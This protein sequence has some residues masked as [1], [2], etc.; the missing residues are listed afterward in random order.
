MAHQDEGDFLLE[1]TPGSGEGMAHQDEG[2]FLLEHTPGSGEGADNRAKRSRVLGLVG[3]VFVAAF[4]VG[5]LSVFGSSEK[6]KVKSLLQDATFLALADDA[7]DAGDLSQ[8]KKALTA[9]VNEQLKEVNVQI[10]DLGDDFKDGVKLVLLLEKVSGERLP[11]LERGRLRFHKV[12]NVNKALHFLQGK[13]AV[14]SGIDAEEVVDGN[15]EVTLDLVWAIILRF[16]IQGIAVGNLSSEDALLAWVQHETAPY[17]NVDVRDFDV[18][19]KDGRAFCALVHKHKPNLIDC[20]ALSKQAAVDNLKTTFDVAEQELGIPKMLDAEDMV[21]LAKPDPRSVEAYLSSCYHV[22]SHSSA[23][24]EEDVAAKFIVKTL[25]FK[26]RGHDAVDEY[27]KIVDDLL[28]WISTRISELSKR[29]DSSADDLQARFLTLADGY[30]ERDRHRNLL[31]QLDIVLSTLKTAW[32]FSHQP[33]EMLSVCGT[34][35]DMQ[36]RWQKLLQAEKDLLHWIRSQGSQARMSEAN[37]MSV[38]QEREDLRS[39]AKMYDELSV[40][41]RSVEGRLYKAIVRSDDTL[42]VMLQ[43]VGDAVNVT[44]DIEPGMQ[45]LHKLYKE[46]AHAMI[47]ENPHIENPQNP[48]GMQAITVRFDDVRASALKLISEVNNTMMLRDLI[49]IPNDQVSEL[50]RHFFHFDKNENGLL[51]RNEMLQC[52]TSLGSE[53]TWAQ[54]EPCG[55]AVTP[56]EFMIERVGDGQEKIVAHL[57]DSFR[58]LAGG[59][60]YVTEEQLQQDLPP[61]QAQYCI[62]HMSAFTGPDAVP[63]ALDYQSLV[64]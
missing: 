27:G 21:K 54:V 25:V 63:G 32:H 60:P 10:E 8:R 1:H 45:E 58:A 16:A 36:G 6:G 20:D 12:S 40:K 2:D 7:D 17:D 5:K 11:K 51:E 29:P 18:S 28:G 14:L 33:S 35:S 9:W 23:Q 4:V 42:E 39:F 37:E 46:V 52:L 26:Q 61:E 49:G 55:V 43:A 57:K 48:D 13:G 34:Y 47:F 22:L 19:F 24:C 64:L 41:I 59:K 44:Q 53:A 56:K 62:A 3:F 15:L 38:Q 31:T 50:R 30:M